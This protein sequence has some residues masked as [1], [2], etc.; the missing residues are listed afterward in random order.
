MNYIISFLECLD[1]QEFKTLSGWDF[2][3]DFP[4][5]GNACRLETCP[6]NGANQYD[7]ACSMNTLIKKDHEGFALPVGL[8]LK[9]LRHEVLVRDYS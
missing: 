9:P 3:V 5:Q 8:K 1:M 6:T 7:Q 2:M 4:T